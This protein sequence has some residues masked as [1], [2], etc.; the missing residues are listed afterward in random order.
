M[1]R[2]SSSNACGDSAASQ[3][4]ASPRAA[5]TGLR[6]VEVSAPLASWAAYRC[7][8]QD[9]EEILPDLRRNQNSFALSAARRKVLELCV[10]IADEYGH[11]VR[12]G[13]R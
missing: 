1:T 11:E 4:P 13:S 3:S 5:G 2:S 7:L 9:L 8:A 10:R 6:S 12:H